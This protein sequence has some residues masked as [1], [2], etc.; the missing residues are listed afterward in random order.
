MEAAQA[1]RE[2]YSQFLPIR[3][4]LV[5]L[6]LYFRAIGAIVL[7]DCEKMAFETG[8]DLY[9]HDLARAR[10]QVL[11]PKVSLFAACQLGP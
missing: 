10:L 2:L 7:V 5:T 11:P 1:R 9:Q 8:K 4:G 3:I 6:P